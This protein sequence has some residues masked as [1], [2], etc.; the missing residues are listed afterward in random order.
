MNLTNRSDYGHR[1]ID[2]L[3]I[4][5]K[6]V[7]VEI[8]GRLCGHVNVLRISK[9]GYPGF[10][11]AELVY[12]HNVF[13]GGASIR[14]ERIESILPVGAAVRIFQVYDGGVGKTVLK[15]TVL[16]SGYI[17]KIETTVKPG[18]EQVI[19]TARDVSVKLEQITV[20]GNVSK[21][22]VADVI[23]QLCD[24]YLRSVD[25]IWPVVERVDILTG[26]AATDGFDV[27]GLNAIEALRKC[28][29]MA[30]IEFRFG[31]IKTDKGLK[32]TIA[33]YKA[34]RLGC[35]EINCQHK[36][37]AFSISKSD[38][39]EFDSEGNGQ[40]IT[41]KTPYVAVGYDVG[42]RVGVS[43]DSRDVFGIRNDDGNV[44][45]ID[46]VVMDFEK[47]ESVLSIVKK[48]DVEAY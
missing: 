20:I 6:T 27:A 1:E 32:E 13:D 41:V 31:C 14:L 12:N 43:P 2:T 18:F 8:G 37:E 30:G 23:L 10:G 28:C 29:D 19:F 4:A 16:F 25:V 35:V 48:T 5:G 47:Q 40:L 9:A 42:R 7:E 15:R 17:E 44:S 24:E 39:T 33:F 45:F 26:G 3:A 34:G 36:G 38:I 21:P 11:S 46:K 22:K